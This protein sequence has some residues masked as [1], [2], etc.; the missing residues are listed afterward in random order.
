LAVEA[1][2]MQ[3]RLA[4]A[5]EEDQA[6]RPLV[7]NKQNSAGGLDGAA[8]EYMLERVGAIINGLAAAFVAGTTSASS[9]KSFLTPYCSLYFSSNRSFVVIDI[10]FKP[11]PSCAKP[12][13][14]IS[15]SLD[16]LRVVV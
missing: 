5:A 16:H 9:R 15:I 10:L 1:D 8:T 4:A 13:T 3:K 6:L 12:P 11:L 7:G 14:V 2:G